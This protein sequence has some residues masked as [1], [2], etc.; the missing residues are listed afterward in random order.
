MEGPK[1]NS[2]VSQGFTAEKTNLKTFTPE[3]FEKSICLCGYHLVCD[4]SSH[5]N[6][7]HTP[8]L[9]SKIMSLHLGTLTVN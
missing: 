8:L 7:K 5:F 6:T 4:F 3:I 2:G 1:L 9:C